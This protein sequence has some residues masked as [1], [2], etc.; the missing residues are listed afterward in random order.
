MTDNIELLADT[1]AVAA[2]RMGISRSLFYIERKAG[3]IVTRQ[4]GR[5]TLVP[6]TEQSRWLSALPVSQVA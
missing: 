5:R 4:I 1:V 3:R 6:R 2:A